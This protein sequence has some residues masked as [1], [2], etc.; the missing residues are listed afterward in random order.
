MGNTVSTA[1]MSDLSDDEVRWLK[2]VMYF[3]RD[4]PRYDTAAG[5]TLGDAVLEGLFRKGFAFSDT[6][7]GAYRITQRGFE[8]LQATA[9]KG[10]L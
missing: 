6:I 9:W 1:V 7:L 4:V 5:Q 3:D 10:R 8:A 2:W